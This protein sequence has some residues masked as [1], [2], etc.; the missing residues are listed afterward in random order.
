MYRDSVAAAKA[1][2]DLARE[3]LEHAQAMRAQYA[4]GT[5]D[6]RL[7]DETVKEA[8]ERFNDTQEE[9]M[10]DLE[11]AL[12]HARDMFD[13][14]MTLMAEDAARIMGGVSGSLEGLSNLMDQYDKTHDT[15]VDAYE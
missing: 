12:Q 7:W 8:Q 6:Y 10:K 2:N 11:E 13:E 5:E 15:F 14:T 9:L 1:R 4:E 3:T